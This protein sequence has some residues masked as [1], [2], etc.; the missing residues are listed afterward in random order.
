M[1]DHCK[2]NPIAPRKGSD[3]PI[4]H[5]IRIFRRVLFVRTGEAITRLICPPQRR[6]GDQ[7]GRTINSARFV[8]HN[9]FVAFEFRWKRRL[10]CP[11]PT[12][13]ARKTKLLSSRT[14]EDTNRITAMRGLPRPV[15]AN[16]EPTPSVNRLI[17]SLM[18]FTTYRLPELPRASAPEVS[19]PWN[20]TPAAT[21]RAVREETGDTDL[22]QST[23]VGHVAATV[24]PQHRP[25]WR[26]RLAGDWFP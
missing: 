17:L 18:K 11:S 4:P 8:V 20:H 24:G 3:P 23:G 12:P 7:E 21:A 2:L 22:S 9:G 25:A 16:M 1:L 14:L 13:T 26:L 10:Q 19:V 15:A 6:S 5:E